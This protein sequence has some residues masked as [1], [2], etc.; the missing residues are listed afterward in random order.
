[1]TELEQLKAD[2]ATLEKERDQG[3]F[4]LA[5]VRVHLN[6][7]A[8]S[9]TTMQLI[10]VL[11]QRLFD[12]EQQQ[13]QANEWAEVNAYIK[14]DRNREK[15]AELTTIANAIPPACGLAKE[16]VERRIEGVKKEMQNNGN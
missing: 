2:L 7:D 9:I 3:N 11:K 16:L 1:M 6:H 8:F 12:L 13:E 10:D 5:S 14:A 4:S 15:L